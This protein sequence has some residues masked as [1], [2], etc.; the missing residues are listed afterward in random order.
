MQRTGHS[1]MNR[2]KQG[3]SIFDVTANNI[4]AAT[5]TQ[6]GQLD[7]LA[8]RALA[9]G[10]QQFIDKKY[11]QAIITLQRAVGLSPR[12]TTAINAYDYMARTFIARGDNQAAAEAYQKALKIDSG[13]DD[14]HLALGNL[15]HS[16]DRFE[17]ARS[18][19][20]QAVKINPS[21]ANRYSL[22]Q[23]YLSTGQ[24]EDALRQFEQVSQ[25]E[26]RKPY[27]DFGLGQ[28]YAKLG[29]Y[30][31]AVASFER[32]IAQ[33]ADYWDAY[34]ELGYTLVDQGEIERAMEIADT[35]KGND[36]Q[37]ASN[38]S[39]YIYEKAAPKM[40]ALYASDIYALFPSTLGPSTEVANLG[41]YLSDPNSSRTF[42][43]VFQFSKQM[44][45]QSVENEQNW[46][47]E[48]NI[49]TGRGDGYN[50]SMPLPTTEVSL[51]STPDAI[52]YDASAMTATVLFKVRQNATGDGT[53]DPSHI[54]FTFKGHD[55]VDL[56]MDAKADEYAGYSGFA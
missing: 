9:Q 43:M 42:S 14:L 23:G 50:Y 35:L 4:F 53:I 56:A 19:Y 20:E 17:E 22:G 33:Q 29:Q 15:Y 3:M 8:Q 32:A 5:L 6:S 48:R 54:K 24:Y 51:P 12:S 16:Q 38:L 37:L 39:S 31:E 10:L 49:G 34:A 46:N 47:I 36:S 41:L 26:R 11:D 25:L 55:L 30:D 52:Y 21:A 18:E 7:N 28:A 45:W 40:T 1:G 44:D 27:G 13:R 2:A